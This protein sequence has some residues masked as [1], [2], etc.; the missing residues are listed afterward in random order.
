VV[1]MLDVHWST[2]HVAMVLGVGP[3]SG[4]EAHVLAV[5]QSIFVAM[6]TTGVRKAS[7]VR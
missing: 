1:A 3:Q 6:V 7:C 4:V 2:L 5:L